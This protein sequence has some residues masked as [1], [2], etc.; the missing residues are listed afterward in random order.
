MEPDGRLHLVAF[1]S[2]KFSDVELNYYIHDKEM[3]VIVDCFQGWRHYL[4]GSPHK[5]IVFTDHHYNRR[6]FRG[7]V[8][9]ARRGYGV[10]PQL[11][12]GP[13]YWDVVQWGDK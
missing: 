11:M 8:T 13:G 1:Y 5:V 2:K 3:V 10:G 12:T 6:V 9:N 4:I 7:L